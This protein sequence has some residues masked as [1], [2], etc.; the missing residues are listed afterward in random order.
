MY[1][2]S[3]G[4]YITLIQSIVE[5]ND[6]DKS[7]HC[8]LSIKIPIKYL[9]VLSQGRKMSKSS[10]YKS[11]LLILLL[12]SA[13]MLAAC[14]S[15]NN[16][17]ASSENNSTTAI[18]TEPET[19]AEAPAPAA[20]A[21]AAPTVDQSVLIA[22]EKLDGT[23]T[24]SGL[25]FVPIE[26]GSGEK[27]QPGQ[28][29]KVAYTGVLADGTVFNSS[30]NTGAYIFTVGAGDVIPGWD[31]GVA[32]LNEGGSAT[33]L[34]PP[35]LGYGDIGAA[36][37]GPGQTLIFDIEL[38]SI[39][40]GAPASPAEVDEADFTETE[41]GLKFYDVEVGDG[42]MP[43]ENYMVT[44]HYTGWLDDGT[45]FD[46]SLDRDTP[47]VFVLDQEQV[48]PGWEEGIRSMKVG[49]KRQLV[50]PAELGYGDEGANNVIPAGET[51]VF[52]IELLDILRNS[53][54]SPV[55]VDEAELTEMESGLKF[56]DIE[57]GDGALPEEGNIVSIHYTGWLA[58]GTKFDSSLGR[59][60]PFVFEIGQEQVI[61]GW[62][63][64]I[65]SM[66]VGG[67][68]QLIVPAALAYGEEGANDVV[69]PDS[70]LIFEVE[71]VDIQQ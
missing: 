55:E 63:E 34:V 41:S 57:A 36:G 35:E 16:D 31:E 30:A 13:L 8:G 11:H 48:I 56:Y 18:E 64:G 5:A 69:P 9:R 52:D 12:I 28:L 19:V 6:E 4:K 2:C 37:V 25:K 23:T 44:V 39:F 33:L 61:P 46:S 66:Q 42:P 50:V 32:M 26:E 45:K 58:D 68:R 27:P 17:D 54:D 21:E 51:L 3:I 29:V 67:Q 7:I 53:P 65:R 70:D 40:E 14:R 15:G 22:V 1:F 43:E 49:G 24:E 62:E 71:L 59:G 10:V 20:A 60:V 47:L 38:M